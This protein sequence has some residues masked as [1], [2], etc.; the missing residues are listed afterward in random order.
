VLKL[1]GEFAEM[2]SIGDICTIAD[3]ENRGPHYDESDWTND[4]LGDKLES[5]DIKTE[6]PLLDW[7]TGEKFVEYLVNAVEGGEMHCLE[8]EVVDQVAAFG[9]S[10][11]KA[12]AN[13][14]NDK[15]Q[16]YDPEY[17]KRGEEKISEE[18]EKWYA[19]RKSAPQ[20]SNEWKADIITQLAQHIDYEGIM[21]EVSESGIV[22]KLVEKGHKEDVICNYLSSVIGYIVFENY[23]EYRG[24]GHP[25]PKI[26]NGNLGIEFL[27]FTKLPTKRDTARVK[28]EL[29]NNILGRLAKRGI[30]LE[31][32]EGWGLELE[33]SEVEDKD[34]KAA[35]ERQLRRDRV[36]TILSTQDWTQ[37]QFCGYIWIG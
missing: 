37:H 23:R 19:K 33:G 21:E 25:V 14:E 3:Q 7:E 1:K 5:S 36:Q 34:V 9:E 28:S 16:Q 17:V 26:K 18:D 6:E 12:R 15:R 27:D 20:E 10:Q 22:E 8:C 30:T 31:L 11:S 35:L 4:T 24:E 13:R 29:V 32:L 2:N